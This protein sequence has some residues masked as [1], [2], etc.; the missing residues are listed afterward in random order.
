[1]D[2]WKSD[3]EGIDNII[4]K[5]FIRTDLCKFSLDNILNLE[6]SVEEV[7]G[8]FFKQVFSNSAASNACWVLAKEFYTDSQ[9]IS[10]VQKIFENNDN[11][12]NILSQAEMEPLVQVFFGKS[13][14][15]YGSPWD[16]FRKE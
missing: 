15:K 10:Y 14:E 4:P 5:I 7:F 2:F 8:Y 16:Y 9:Y 3:V 6:W 1:M 13:T 11:Q 12:F